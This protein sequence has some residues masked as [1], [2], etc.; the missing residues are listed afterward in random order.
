MRRFLPQM[1]QLASMSN[2]FPDFDLE[3]KKMYLEQVQPK[4]N[5]EQLCQSAHTF[6]TSEAWNLHPHWQLG[7]SAECARASATVMETM[8]SGSAL[9]V[10][11]PIALQVH[12]IC[13]GVVFRRF[14]LPPPIPVL[15]LPL[16]LPPP[17]L[18]LP[19]LGLLLCAV[20]HRLQQRHPTA[21]TSAWQ[22][23]EGTCHLLPA[24]DACPRTGC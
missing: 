19:M 10:W 21:V 13:S 14:H 16:L 9:A 11:H 15:P 4:S 18:W 3:G 7:S 6:A 1:M 12:P 24:A 17:R 23:A 20:R 5:P 2:K 8:K 22:A